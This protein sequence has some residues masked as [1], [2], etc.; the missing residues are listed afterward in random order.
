[1]HFELPALTRG[2]ALLTAALV[3]L[4]MLPLPIHRRFGPRRTEPRSDE[5]H[6][7]SE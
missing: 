6:S 3:H 1:M 2:H 5:V 7:K 4:S